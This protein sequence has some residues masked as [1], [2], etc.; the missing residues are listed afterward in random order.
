MTTTGREAR[1]AARVVTVTLSPAL[2]R[3]YLLPGPLAAGQFHR[4]ARVVVEGSGKG[5]NVSRA[6]AAHDVASAAVLPLGGEEGQQLRGLLA[7]AAD[8]VDYRVLDVAA[9]TRINITVVEP[10]GR[11]TKVNAPAPVLT[12]SDLARLA[13]VLR[14]ALAQHTA[15][16]VAFCGAVP[17]DA[18]QELSAS[19]VLAPLV[20]VARAA[21]A[22]VGV[23]TSGTALAAALELGVDLVKP[24]EDELAELTGHPVADHADAAE[25]AQEIARRSGATVLVSLGADGA[26]AATRDEVVLAE[27]PQVEVVNTTGAGDAFL[28]GWLAAMTS[29]AG[30]GDPGSTY[31]SGLASEPESG[32]A[33]DAALAQAVAWGTAACL[34]P[35]TTASPGAFPF[36]D[37]SS[38]PVRRLGTVPT[39]GGPQPA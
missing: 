7:S 34:M 24:N 39:A 14:D 33:L 9:P 5:V 20:D 28:A 13:D 23:D 38:V 6:L 19:A 26:L 10:G 30:T 17:T 2:D 27:A 8:S 29:Y 3:T 11:T 36:V 15:S 25:R 22:G 12:R 16:W 1:G 35:G 21:G 37:P 18:E 4:S 32:P 31:G